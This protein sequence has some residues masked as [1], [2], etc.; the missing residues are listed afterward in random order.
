MFPNIGFLSPIK[1]CCYP[2]PL[3]T[4]IGQV[5][6]GSPG[7][8]YPEDA[9]DNLSVV[10]PQ[11]YPFWVG[12]VEVAILNFPTLRYLSLLNSSRLPA[13]TLLFSRIQR[14]KKT[15]PKLLRFLR[16]ILILSLKFRNVKVLTH[17]FFTIPLTTYIFVK[18]KYNLKNESKTW[19]I[20]LI[21]FP[22]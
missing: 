9:L 12:A 2:F 3:S 10:V 15:R 16:R 1:P 20:L 6:P 11:A 13:G 17:M 4:T 7:S 19:D 14:G 5:S 18:K 8:E 21:R 22:E